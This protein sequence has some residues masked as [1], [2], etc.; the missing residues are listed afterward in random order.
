MPSSSHKTAVLAAFSHCL[1]LEVASSGLFIA[2]Y[3]RRFLALVP[4]GSLSMKE[5][6]KLNENYV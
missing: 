4:V 2:V 1:Q 6:L 3:R 5:V